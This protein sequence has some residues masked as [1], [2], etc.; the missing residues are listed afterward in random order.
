M[1]PTWFVVLSSRRFFS[2]ADGKQ[3]YNFFRTTYLNRSEIPA[4]LFW[5]YCI[6]N[7]LLNGLNWF[8]FSK[9]VKTVRRKFASSR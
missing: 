8:W 7:V 3:S 6:G 1:V 9:M 4:A 2:K 5:T